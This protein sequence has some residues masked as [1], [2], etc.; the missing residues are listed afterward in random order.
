MAEVLK[1]ER[2]RQGIYWI[3]AK[4]D[5]DHKLA[6]FTHGEEVHDRILTVHEDRFD[7]VP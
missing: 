2:D 3:L 7:Y 1:V 4:V 5:P 6:Q